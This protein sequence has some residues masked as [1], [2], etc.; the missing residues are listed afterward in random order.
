MVAYAH[1]VVKAEF[2]IVLILNHHI[3]VLDQVIS[4]VHQLVHQ[5]Q[6]AVLV[7]LAV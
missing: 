5:T 1:K 2:P 3:S 6:V 7:M 4:V